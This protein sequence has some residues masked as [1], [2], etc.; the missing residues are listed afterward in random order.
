[1]DRNE[2][3]RSR[4]LYLNLAKEILETNSGQ[5]RFAIACGYL[6]AGY[7][8]RH[9]IDRCQKYKNNLEVCWIEI[10]QK[11]VALSEPSMSENNILELYDV[12]ELKRLKNVPAL[13]KFYDYL[14]EKRIEAA[15]KNES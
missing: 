11:V 3:Y 4:K 13:R 10:L 7:T 6:F 14:Y 12:C 9:G 5:K 1:M 15:K 2:K 8:Y